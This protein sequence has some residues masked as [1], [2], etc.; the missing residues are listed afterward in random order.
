MNFA[1]PMYDKPTKVPNTVTPAKA[2][3]QFAR[4]TFPRIVT[5][6]TSI[7]GEMEDYESKEIA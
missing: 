7:K 5:N 2:G 1:F 4:T 3:D 6:S